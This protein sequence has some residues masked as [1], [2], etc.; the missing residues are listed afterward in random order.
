MSKKVAWAIKTRR[1]TFVNQ[2][3]QNFWEAERTM[4]FRTRKQAQTWLGNSHYWIKKGEAV[5]VTVT[6]R[7]YME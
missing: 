7:E 6:I 3:P 2:P 4:L 5:K 1:D